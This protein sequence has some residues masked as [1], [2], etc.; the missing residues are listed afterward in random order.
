MSG[1]AE[2]NEKPC[3]STRAFQAESDDRPMVSLCRV[4][5]PDPERGLVTVSFPLHPVQEYELLLQ[6]AYGDSK[7]K[8]DVKNLLKLLKPPSLWFHGPT[9]IIRAKATTCKSVFWGLRVEMGKV[10]VSVERR[11][12]ML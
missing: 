12:V 2:V 10:G 6:V 9:K 3:G 11:Q 5:L 4:S 7:E 8:R 1:G